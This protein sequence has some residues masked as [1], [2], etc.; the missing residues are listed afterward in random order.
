MPPPACEEYV[1]TTRHYAARSVRRD[2]HHSTL[3]TRSGGIFVSS[4]DVSAASTGG[5]PG[6]RGTARYGR[7]RGGWHPARAQL[8]SQRSPSLVARP[9]SNS[10]SPSGVCTHPAPARPGSAAPGPRDRSR[11]Q[12]RIEQRE[13]ERAVVAP[14]TGRLA[15]RARG[16]QAHL[17]DRRRGAGTRRAPRRRPRRDAPRSRRPGTAAAP[18]ARVW[19]VPGRR[20]KPVV[21]PTLPVGTAELQIPLMRHASWHS[22]A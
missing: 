12:Q 2:H 3:R 19:A 7:R 16:A 5:R 6:G 8:C 22:A 20:D 17:A 4:R 1:Q 21:Q 13:H 15:M 9:M 11:R 10:P 14:G 18:C